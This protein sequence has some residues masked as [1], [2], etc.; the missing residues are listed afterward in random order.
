MEKMYHLR[1]RIY[2]LLLTQPT[3]K[4]MLNTRVSFLYTSTFVVFL[5]RK[6][7]H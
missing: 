6:V 3:W 4:Q 2:R 7:L 1:R 5:T